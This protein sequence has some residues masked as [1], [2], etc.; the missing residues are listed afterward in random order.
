[1]LFCH[2]SCRAHEVFFSCCL[3]LL[4]GLPNL[5][6]QKPISID[7]CLG[8]PLV[9]DMSTSVLEISESLEAHKI[10]K[11]YFS[12]TDY[13]NARSQANSNPRLSMESFWGLFLITGSA[14]VLGLL[15]Y[16]GRL[17]YT[18]VHHRIPQEQ[19]QSPYLLTVINLKRW[20][21]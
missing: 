10:Q 9:S 21:D 2:T 15:I 16:L 7:L 18:Y 11:A 5:A 20:D 17:L 19:Q 14:S 4:P 1:M 13:N 6:F 3:R 12:N 8:S